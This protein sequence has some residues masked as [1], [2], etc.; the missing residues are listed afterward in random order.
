MLPG[1]SSD[2]FNCSNPSGG[3]GSELDCPG[4]WKPMTDAITVTECSWV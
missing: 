3:Q 1:N 2:G 4:V